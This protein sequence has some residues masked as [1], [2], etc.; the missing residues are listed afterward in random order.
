MSKQTIIVTARNLFTRYGIKGVSMSQVSD[1]IR[2]SKKT[3][4]SYFRSKEELICACMDFENENISEMLND[5][6]EQKNNPVKSVVSLT[7]KIHQFNG[8]CCPAFY[9]DIQQF[10]DAN[11]KLTSIHVLIQENLIAY[12][13]EG[14]EKGLFLPNSNYELISYGLLEQMKLQNR[15]NILYQLSLIYAFI[16][17]LC[18]SDGICLLNE[19]MPLEMRGMQM[20]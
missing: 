12:L 13:K 5:M 1:S 2:I 11:I 19:L 6:R 14:E 9:K 17:G 20:L 16:R 10:H 18:T 15:T 4:Y 3:L 7:T 8:F